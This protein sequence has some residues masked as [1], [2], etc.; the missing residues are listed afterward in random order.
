MGKAKGGL[1]VADALDLRKPLVKDFVDPDRE[2]ENFVQIRLPHIPYAKAHCKLLYRSKDNQTI[3]YRVNWFSEKTEAGCIVPL[4][5]IVHSRYYE[6]RIKSS[7][8]ELVD[9]TDK[10]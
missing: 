8:P 9:L 7:G 6:L 5:S 3:R 4:R 2:V 1:A 10:Q